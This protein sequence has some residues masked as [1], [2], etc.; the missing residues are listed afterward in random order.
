MNDFKKFAQT[1]NEKLQHYGAYISQEDNII[2]GLKNEAIVTIKVPVPYFDEFVND[3]SNNA[4]KIIEKSIRTDDV[5]GQIVDTK[6]R[7][8]AKKQMRQKYLEFLKE[9][10]N[11]GEVIQVQNE[12]NAIQEQIE[13]TTQRYASLANQTAYSTIQLTYTQLF[14]GVVADDE[15][16]DGFFKK[17]INAFTTGGSFLGDI[18]IGL[19]NIWPL[20]LIFIGAFYWYKNNRQAANVKATS[21]SK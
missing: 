8:E 14:D 21:K 20:V 4:Q 18:I 9:S 5:T 16:N 13:A 6:A 19:M 12:I 2:N 3:C 7:L 15:K 17:V 11:V 10:K 1:L